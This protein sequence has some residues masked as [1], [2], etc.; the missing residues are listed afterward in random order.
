MESIVL[1]SKFDTVEEIKTFRSK[2]SSKVSIPP[3]KKDLERGFMPDC[4][5]DKAMITKDS[6]VRFVE[7]RA[8]RINLTVACCKLDIN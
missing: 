5:V 8:S 3:S 6:I 4:S 2:L 7:D 1:G